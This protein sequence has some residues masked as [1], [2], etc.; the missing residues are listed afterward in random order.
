MSML[1]RGH[2]ELLGTLAVVASLVFVGVE[3]RQNSAA[4]RAAA[5][6]QLGQSW[7]DWNVA[8]TS[9]DIQEALVLVAQFE[10]PSEA[11]IVEQRMAESF[12]RSL[13][14]NW[15]ISHYQYRAGVLDPPLWEGV[16]RDMAGGG[17][18]SHSFGRLLTWSWKRN[19]YLYNTEFS[20][21]MDSV[22][23]AAP[24]R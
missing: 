10:D 23:A 9:R 18:T 16:L 4:M 14:S 7:I 1:A 12:A 17:D 21:L 3:I 24:R 22:V 20:A 2:L 5:S 8:M 19:H 6:Q 13:F 15:S 11:P